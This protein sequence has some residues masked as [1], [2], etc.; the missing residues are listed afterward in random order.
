MAVFTSWSDLRTTLLNALATWAAGDPT[1]HSASLGNQTFTWNSPEDIERLILMTY[2]MEALGT[3]GSRS[4][5]VS[6]GRFRRFNS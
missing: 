4:T 3:S 1:V 2:R 6:V 5:R